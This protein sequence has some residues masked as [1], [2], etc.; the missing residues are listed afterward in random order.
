M[1]VFEHSFALI[2]LVLGLALAHVLTELVRAVRT[3]GFKLLGLLTPMLAIF[4]I[5]DIGTWWGILWGM[6]D[7][8]PN[9]WPVLGTGLLISS[10]YY[11]AALL[12]FPESRDDWLDLDDYYMRHRRVVFGLMFL[13]FAVT[14]VLHSLLSNSL[15]VDIVAITYFIILGLTWLA[16]WRRANLI[17]LGA[18][19]AADVWAFCY[20]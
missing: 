4:V 10:L 1:T 6:R 9:I 13:C 20:P 15:A 3:H 2:G 11:V 16:P 8:L 18:L 5:L 14:T 17:G 19:I 12:V 7:I